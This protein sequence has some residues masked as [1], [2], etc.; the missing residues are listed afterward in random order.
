MTVTSFN[1][2][3]RF[4]L[5]SKTVIP[6]LY[7]LHVCFDLLKKH[8]EKVELFY[9]REDLLQ[10]KASTAHCHNHNPEKEKAKNYM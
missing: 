6:T 2:V 10:T 4:Q 7:L 5:L 1:L 8:Q 9:D 3:H